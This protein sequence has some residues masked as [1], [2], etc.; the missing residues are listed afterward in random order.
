VT[1]KF[2]LEQSWLRTY[3]RLKTYQEHYGHTNL[4]RNFTD[5]K[6]PHLGEWVS[7]QRRAFEL[8]KWTN[9]TA[10]CLTQEREDLLNSL[11]NVWEL[12]WQPEYDSAWMVQLEN[13][14]AFKN[15]YNTTKIGQMPT[16][17][18]D[19]VTSISSWAHKQRC[20]YNRFMANKTTAITQDKIDLLNSIGFA[21][22]L[23]NKTLHKEWLHR[24]FKLYWYHSQ[25]NNTNDTLASGCNFEF[26]NWVS[27]QKIKYQAGKLDQGKIDLMNELNFDCM[28]DPSATWKE[29]SQELSQYKEQF[30]STLV[31]KNINWELGQW[32]AE[33][34]QL[35][36][37]G[38]LD[39][40]RTC[41]LNSLEF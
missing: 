15:K 7:H 5:E 36:V 37:T 6:E 14:K 1:W 16:S 33:M 34:R 21:W 10:D 22:S 39:L 20:E 2:D 27:I 40:E 8:R 11:G 29:I 18:R 19:T 25:H 30:G 32:T 13:F 28:P 9:G 12:G 24:Y 17:V 23:Q 26:V 38:D 3:D 31:N 41:S 35:H 4:L